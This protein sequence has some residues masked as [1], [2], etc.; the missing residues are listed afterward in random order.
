MIFLDN[1]SEIVEFTRLYLA[2]FYSCVAIFYLTR[3]FMVR[4][5]S[6]TEVVFT[7]ERFCSTWWNHMVFR[8]F[9]FTIWMVCLSRFYY[10][11]IDNYLGI[12]PSLEK[13]PVVLAGDIIL[14]SGFLLTIS[15][16]FSMGRKWRS[17]IDPQSPDQL[18]TDG[19]YK[20]SRN[21]MFISVAFCQIG[22]FLALPSVF[23]LT[24]LTIGLYVLY[25]QA[26]CEERHLSEVFPIKY[27][28]YSND[29]HRWL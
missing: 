4:K 8:V 17:G 23:S 12:I 19:F 13:F 10:P 18:I 26:L 6:N 22:F 9:R 21:P 5:N 15:I 2:I 27:R 16:H 20:Y 28:I 11:P 24:C 29:V 1:T 3:I 7:G 14:T 25:R